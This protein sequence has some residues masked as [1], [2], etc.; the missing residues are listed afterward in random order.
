MSQSGVSKGTKLDAT[1]DKYKH[2]QQGATWRSWCE[3]ITSLSPKTLTSSELNS[4][5]FSVTIIRVSF[6]H[7]SANCLLLPPTALPHNNTS[8][9]AQKTNKKLSPELWQC[10]HDHLAGG[11]MTMI[12]QASSQGDSTYQ[13]RCTTQRS[14]CT[15][16]EISR[17]RQLLLIDHP[18]AGFPVSLT[19]EPGSTYLLWWSWWHCHAG[20]SQVC[21]S[22]AKQQVI[23]REDWSPISSPRTNLLK[24]NSAAKTIASYLFMTI[25]LWCAKSLYNKIEIISLPILFF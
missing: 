18:K 10:P 4:Q 24:G 17:C 7:L 20:S 16:G 2:T 6:T 12:W 3:S 21:F 22:K 25:F 1:Q 19:A 13:S 8:F 15:P 9:L 5:S 11:S 14:S 23:S